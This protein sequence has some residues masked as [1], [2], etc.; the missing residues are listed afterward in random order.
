MPQ[1][2]IS[3]HPPYLAQDL[4]GRVWGGG[5]GLGQRQSLP[6]INTFTVS[7]KMAAAHFPRGAAASCT[8]SENGLD[9]DIAPHGD[10]ISAHWTVAASQVVG[11]SA[12]YQWGLEIEH[13]IYLPPSHQ[14]SS[15]SKK[16]K[17]IF[18]PVFK[19]LQGGL[20]RSWVTCLGDN[21]H[22]PPRSNSG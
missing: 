8:Q 4:E 3:K 1:V 6:S 20:E 19:G 12:G 15:I 17:R 21:H 22:R 10:S 11:S 16:Q 7:S 9:L 14:R 2:A 18:N 5:R 13:S